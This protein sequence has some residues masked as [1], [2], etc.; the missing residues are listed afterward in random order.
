MREYIKSKLIIDG[1][2]I[3]YPVFTATEYLMEH[4][5]MS[6]NEIEE[7]IEGNY[8]LYKKLNQII[9][10]KQSCYLLRRT[11]YSCGSLSDDL[12]SLK[13]ELILKLHSLYGYD[14]DDAWMENLIMDK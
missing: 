1:R 2:N 8:D 4:D 14:F 3:P 11:S 10:L 5:G 7:F 13:L 6:E 9:A 12:Y